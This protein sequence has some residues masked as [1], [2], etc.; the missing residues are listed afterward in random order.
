MTRLTSIEKGGYYAFPPA[1]LPALASLFAP[2]AHGGKLLDP[3][4]GEGDALQAL[5]EAWRLEPYANELDIPRAAACQRKFGTH[6]VQGDLYQLRASSGAFTAAWCN[7]PYTWDNAGDDKRREFAMLKEC[8]KWVQDGGFML[9]C[10]YAHHITPDAALYLARHSAQVDVWRLPGLHLDAYTHIIVVSRMGKP[11]GDP[12]AEAARLVLAAQ[13]HDFPELTPQ[14]AP[15]YAFPRPTSPKTFIFTPNV[16]TA[17][18]VRLALETHSAHASTGF[19]ALIAPPPPAPKVQPIVRPR[20][21]QLALILAAGLFN[22]LVLDTE[23]GPAAVRSTTQPVEQLL[24]H[25]QTG[26]GEQSTE[27]EVYRTQPVVTITLLTQQGAVIDISGEQAMVEF[28]QQ[29]R[30]ALLAYID[31]EL[32]PLYHFDYSPIAPVLA[33]SKGGRLYPVQRHVIAATYTALQHRRGVIMVGE[34]GTGKTIMGA[35]LAAALRPQMRKGQVTLILCP[36]HLVEKWSREVGEST[37]L[38]V[39]RILRTA[40]D[41]H[42]FMDEAQVNAPAR[43]YVGIISR[44]MAKLGEGWSVAINWRRGL[45][46]RFTRWPIGEPPENL[47]EG[48]Q[49][50][51]TLPK[52]ICPACSKVILRENDELANLAWLQR[53]PRYCKHCGGALWQQARTFSAPNPAKGEKY[54]KRDPRVPLAE[55]IAKR[56]PGRVYL[57]LADEI[58]ENKSSSTD[59][60][61]ALMVLAGAAEK[62][63]GLTG[64]IYGGSAST[65]YA[66]EFTFS[67]RMRADYPWGAGGLANW[68]RDMGCLERI[69]EYKPQYDKAGAYSGKRRVECAPREAP[70]CSP[71][72]VSSVIDHAIFVG[73]SDMGRAMPAY[74]EIPVPIQHDPRVVA[75]YDEAKETLS[76]YLFKRRMEGDSSAL[77]MYLQAL[78]CWPSAPWRAEECIHRRRIDRESDEFTEVH[79]HTIPALGEDA[80]YPKEQWLVDTVRAE[81][82][83]GRGVAVFLRQTGT[84]D[85][86]PRIE[87]IL[88]EHVPG[89]RPFVLRSSVEAARRESVIARQVSLGVN[90]LLANAKLCATGLDLV[91]FPSICFYEVDY[92]L[93]TMSQASRRAWRL[94][95]TRECRTYYPYYESLMEHQAIELIGRKQ[96]AANLLYG[97]VGA[98]GLGALSGCSGSSLLAELAAAVGQDAAVTDLRDLFAQHAHQVDPTESAWFAGEEDAPVVEASVVV[99]TTT[100]TAQPA[101]AVPDWPVRQAEHAPGQQIGLFEAPVLVPEMREEQQPGVGRQMRLL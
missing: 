61:E 14:P 13:A 8:W 29:H 2:S 18:T 69:V 87:R 37:N 76:E 64:T 10:I 83:E 98:G 1:H 65:L 50:I 82:A 17:E 93:Y 91:D 51:V 35:T 59:Q 88:R 16:L 62:V 73:L 58:H 9:W 30:A 43:L 80:L 49:R 26:E 5:T 53:R 54:P 46:E 71:R 11:A 70:G 28:I 56:Y 39:T 36:P 55:H 81:L 57:L 7:P 23:H 19:Q 79:V 90:V 20:G 38:A 6:A 3:C 52:P 60:G 33:R 48:E 68:V 97:E 42:A 74:R 12:K 27:R 75:L 66:I 96:E 95:Q 4:A 86:Q 32:E 67:P 78:L 63:V 77:G 41:V 85:I 92:S 25:E 40:A 31:H 47:A 15:R 44:E 94:I 45:R 24:S 72:L 89:V 22:G 100:E 84:R 101:I 34:M 99:A 21:G